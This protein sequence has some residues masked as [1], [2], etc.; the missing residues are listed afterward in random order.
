MNAVS[1]L[2]APAWVGDAVMSEPLL[3]RITAHDHAPVDVL[4]PP[5]V[6]PVF[7][8]MPGVG[9]VIAAPFAHGKLDLGARRQAGSALKAHAYQNAYVLPN[10]LKSALPP[11][12]AGIPNRI[13][14]TGECRYGLLNH[15]HT[16][17]KQALPRMVDRFLALAP[18]N[19]R[20]LAADHAEP[21]LHAAPNAFEGLCHRLGLTRGARLAVLCPGAEFG[22]AKRWPAE[23]FAT[24][25]RDLGALGWTVWVIGSNKDASMGE[26]IRQLSEGVAINLCGRTSLA[27]A[28][29]LLGGA[30]VVVSNDSGLMHVA[31]ALDRPLVALYGSSSPAFTPPLAKRVAILQHAVPCSPCFERTCRYGHLD[32]LTQLT[33]SQAL[34]AIQS[35]D[36][37]PRALT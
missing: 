20:D 14:F 27:D 28:I 3:R 18:V 21:V 36:I 37:Q 6:V 31:A 9:Q 26:S 29:D 19:G 25:A 17:N 23:H 1:L 10:S 15:R 33:P 34:A 5:W 32:C 7:E 22:P 13:G 8:R 24:L 30:D 4:A 16:L 35:F 2:V 11:F 12:F